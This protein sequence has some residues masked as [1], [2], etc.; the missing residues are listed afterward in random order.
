MLK[1][2]LASRQEPIHYRF[3]EL[4]YGSTSSLK[5]KRQKAK[6]GPL[7]FICTQNA[8]REEFEV[9]QQPAK[10]RKKN[11]KHITSPERFTNILGTYCRLNIPRIR[12]GHVNPGGLREPYLHNLGESKRM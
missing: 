11:D 4:V 9:D 8:K 6:K 2:P 10:A 7:P 1:V 5:A 12:Q 3:P